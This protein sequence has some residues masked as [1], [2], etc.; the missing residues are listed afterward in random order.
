MSLPTCN[1]TGCRRDRSRCVGA[2][3]R[4]RCWK[5]SRRTCRASGPTWLRGSGGVS[6]PALGGLLLGLAVSGGKAREVIAQALE[7]AG[8]CID[9]VV[10]PVLQH[11]RERGHHPAV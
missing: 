4:R 3:S 5:E 2:R 10:R 11:A 8:E 7:A 1:P 6:W 9:V